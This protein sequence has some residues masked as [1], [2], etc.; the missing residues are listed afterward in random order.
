MNSY[1]YYYTHIYMNG[2]FF[3][4]QWNEIYP[5][6]DFYSTHTQTSKNLVYED[7]QF[8]HFNKNIYKS[9]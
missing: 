2:A 3:P 1:K 5:F 4:K 6:N 7:E 9:R 8:N